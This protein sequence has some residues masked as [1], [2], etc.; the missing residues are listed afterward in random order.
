MCYTTR[1]NDERASVWASLTTMISVKW[2]EAK[3]DS[4]EKKGKTKKNSTQEV[5]AD[6]EDRKDVEEKSEDDEGDNNAT[7]SATDVNSKDKL[8]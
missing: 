8:E 1:L 7:P 2:V 4:K 5:L 6:E 3:K